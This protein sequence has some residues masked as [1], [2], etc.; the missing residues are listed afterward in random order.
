MQ[1]RTGW[2]KQAGRVRGLPPQPGGR[3]PAPE[4][5]GR[6]KQRSPGP[7]AAPRPSSS[8]EL[9]ECPA[10]A[11]PEG[12]CSPQG[13]GLSIRGHAPRC[14][15]PRPDMGQCWW[16]GGRLSRATLCSGLP[17][18]G[19]DPQPQASFPV[20]PRAALEPLLWKPTRLHLLPPVGT[21]SLGPCPCRGSPDLN[22]RRAV[23]T[24]WVLR[25]PAGCWGGEGM[26][27][28]GLP[29]WSAGS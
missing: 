4:Q 11:C 22:P 25:D 29:A 17:S 1:G 20:L 28:A 18:A 27:R 9:Q 5:Q 19:G 7:R 23:V 14:C 21:P 24:R 16:A 8:Q 26:G 6:R 2:G 15:Q 3:A 10:L 12:P 13:T